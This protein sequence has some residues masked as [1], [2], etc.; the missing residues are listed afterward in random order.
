MIFPRARNGFLWIPENSIW[1]RVIQRNF[2]LK[3]FGKDFK[4]CTLNVRKILTG[5]LYPLCQKTG[6]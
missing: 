6:Q 3:N 5:D 2:N 4:I 1:E